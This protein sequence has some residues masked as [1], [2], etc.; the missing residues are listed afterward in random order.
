MNWDKFFSLNLK[1]LGLIVLAW[2]VSVVLHNFIS[3]IFGFEEPVFFILAVIV[4]PIYF[5]VSVFY[6]LGKWIK[7]GGMKEFLGK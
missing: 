5:F 2:F 4:I 3:S 1:R 7:S 6:T